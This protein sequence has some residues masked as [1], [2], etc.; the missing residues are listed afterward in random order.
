MAVLANDSD[1]DGDPLQLL[2]TTQPASGE[3]SV[4]ARRHLTFTPAAPGPAE[5]PLQVG[6]G[7]GGTAPRPSRCSSIPPTASCRGR[8]SRGSTTSSWPSRARLRGRHRARGGA[9]RGRR[10]S[11][12][13]RPSP[14]PRVQVRDRA[15]PVDRA[16]GGEFASATYIVVEGGLLVVTEDGR[17][18]YLVGLRAERRAATRRSRSRWR[19]GR[20]S[21]PISCWPT[22]S[23]SRCPPRGRWS[24]G[25]SRRR[26]ASSM[27]A[28]RAS[29]PT[30]RATSAP[31]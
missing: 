13:G 24:A 30:R 12:S 15:R 26:P 5:L 11:W 10:R 14:A 18:V 29:A 8:C 2:D 6:D 27:A 20:R 25:S 21:R 4:D 23:R 7:Q 22:C 16:A 28:A 1:P 17:L 31:G 3:V 9:A 19:A